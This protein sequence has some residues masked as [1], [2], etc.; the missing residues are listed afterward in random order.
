MD[1]LGLEAFLR[2][3]SS[4]N[5]QNGPLAKKKSLSTNLHLP[6]AYSGAG[7]HKKHKHTI[8]I[9]ITIGKKS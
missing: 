9:V 5:I 3:A 8:N 7:N 1:I 2:F 4:Q 6:S